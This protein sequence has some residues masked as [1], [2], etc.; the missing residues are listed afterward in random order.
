MQ[1]KCH[2]LTLIE[3]IV[4]LG[5]VAVLTTMVLNSFA[6]IKSREAENL[7]TMRGKAVQNV[8]KGMDVEGGIS[9]FL[10]DMGRWPRVYVPALGDGN[11]G[12][13][14]AE[15]YDPTVWYYE[16]SSNT[17]LNHTETIEAKTI[18]S[19]LNLPESGKFVDGLS[20]PTVTMPVGWRGPYLDL[21]EPI[22]ANY[23]DGWG[24][25][26]NIITNYNL[27]VASN[28]LQENTGGT[29]K[30]QIY[31][32]SSDF[33]EMKTNKTQC[34]IDG[35]VSYGA[36]RAEDRDTVTASD[37]DQTFLF[38]HH[39]DIHS[40]NATASLTVR[41]KVRDNDSATW[42]SP[43]ATM[44]WAKNIVY[45]VGDVVTQGG[46]LYYC[47]NSHTSGDHFVVTNFYALSGASAFQTNIDYAVGSLCCYDGYL[48]RC[49][50]PLSAPTN[51]VWD[52][53]SWD[54]L[55]PVTTIPERIS[56][57]LFV[58]VMQGE[59]NRV[60]KLGYYHFYRNTTT[61]NG[62]EVKPY[63]KAS[64]SATAVDDVDVSSDNTTNYTHYNPR[65]LRAEDESES[66]NE[67]QISRLVPGRRK[68]FCAAY[69]DFMGVYQCS[70]V[71]W[72]DLRPGENHI[73]L[74]LE[75]KK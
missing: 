16:N 36:D 32:I 70:G 11:G 21:Q 47:H 8:M 68:I 10:S 44:P 43:S 63:Y 13:R 66:W 56:L 37:A 75:R 15:L 34:R 1:I 29:N 46:K 26:W 71:E 23:F 55:C 64:S 45:G 25:A 57:L 50:N 2:K 20:Y 3:L 22:G 74:Y 5:I 6:D 67:F 42:I 38:P 52:E 12:R 60:M 73:T 72:V 69:G 17:A 7:T 9:R 58:P 35:I 62:S 53:S 59:T 33:D 61:E 40:K 51:L 4:C 31:S 49:S 41:L 19:I 24:R 27:E 28:Q 14:L 54:K 30:I 48:W 39:M 65:Y 18:Q